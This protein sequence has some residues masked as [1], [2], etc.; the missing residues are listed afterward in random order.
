MAYRDFYQPIEYAVADSDYLKEGVAGLYAALNT[1]R[2][3][4]QQAAKDFKYELKGKSESDQKLLTEYAKSVFDQGYNELLKGR[5]V[6][7]DT[8][9]KMMQGNSYAE[10]SEIQYQEAD[11]LQKEILAR[12]TKDPYYNSAPALKGLRLAY[13]GESGEKNFL[14]RD[15]KSFA[16]TIDRVS[17][18]PNESTFNNFKFRSDYVKAFKDKVVETSSKNPNVAR[19]KYNQA[20]FWDEEKNTPGVTDQHAI[21][22]LKSDGRVDQYFSAAVDDQ[23]REEIKRM[24]AS[25]DPRVAW[26]SG[27]NAANLTGK[28]QSWLPEE[29]IMAKLI[30]DPTKNIINSKAYGERKRE[31]AKQDLTLADR[32]NS[33]VSV[34]YMEPKETK[35][36][37]GTF[38]T[39]AH[40]STFLTDTFKTPTG[41]LDITPSVVAGPGGNIMTKKGTNPGKPI[42][43]DLSTD[44]AFSLTE[45]RMQSRVNGKFNVTGYQL[46]LTDL[47][48]N[49]VPLSANSLLELT[50]KIQNMKPE[51]FK[52]LAPSMKVAIKGYSIDES[53]MLGDI[54]RQTEKLND[55]IATA[56]EEGDDDKVDR[57]KARLDNLNQLRGMYN[58]PNAMDDDIVNSALAAGVRQIRID[59]LLP[60]NNADLDRINSLTGLNLK[61]ES[62][63]SDDMKLVQKMYRQKYL[64]AQE[65]NFGAVSTDT[66]TGHP[67]N[68][69]IPLKIEKKKKEVDTKTIT[70]QEE[71]EAL[72]SGTVYIFNGKQYKKK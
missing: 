67:K 8:K 32:V 63:W 68:E 35:N 18:N 56:E 65:A 53:K 20:V 19:S 69:T 25:G 60:G 13:E 49:I 33:K 6:S 39:I 5:G 52:N 43:T 27:G 55:D 1:K 45:G 44:K 21:D 17:T 9:Q 26:M 36:P 64:E 66:S 47:S 37:D 62:K 50:T 10:M 61:D 57:L 41:S 59:Q 29:E 70:S 51:D 12:E 46:A 15:L 71:Y 48:N 14:N 16:K 58:T 7:A 54:S 31:L 72:P 24:K 42:T 2:T 30:S 28:K 3:Q 22:Y 34:E 11:K 38:D 40:G 23:L 4:Q